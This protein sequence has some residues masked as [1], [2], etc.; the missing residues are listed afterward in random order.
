MNVYIVYFNERSGGVAMV[1]RNKD[2][3]REYIKEGNGL[4]MT[5]IDTF[6]VND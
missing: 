2:K 1:F 3:A 6:V 5:I 4:Y